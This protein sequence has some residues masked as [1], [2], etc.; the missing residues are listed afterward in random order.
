MHILFCT[1]HHFSHVKA[2]QRLDELVVDP[3]IWTGN[4]YL[5][6]GGR[7]QDCPSLTN[8]YRSP[9]LGKPVI[10]VQVYED[11]VRGTDTPCW[12]SN[13][14]T[15]AREKSNH[16]HEDDDDHENMQQQ[17]ERAVRN[18]ISVAPLSYS[19]TSLLRDFPW[20]S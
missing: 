4:L 13:F 20:Q 19:P 3:L 5:S 10:D 9:P 12:Q 6:V 16:E 11:A 18:S 15:A 14:P 17:N 2:N 8:F 7:R 1:S